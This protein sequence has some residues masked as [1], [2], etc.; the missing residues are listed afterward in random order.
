MEKR[1]KLYEGK[2]KIIYTTDY[3]NTIIQHFKDDITAFNNKKKET[4]AEKGKLNNAISTTIFKLLDANGITTHYLN[5]LPGSD[6]D[7]VCFKLDM[8]PIE[9]VIRNIVAGSLATRMGVK[10]GTALSKPIIEFYYKNDDLGDP[11]INEDHIQAFNLATEGCV[12]FLKTETTKINTILLNWFT[13]KQLTLVDMKLEFGYLALDGFK[14]KKILVGDEISP[15]TCRLWDS[16]TN[17]KLDKD[18]FRKELG[19][20]QESYQEIYNRIK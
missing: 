14:S 13:N 4:I 20:V 16:K 9:I 2:A 1:D 5:S 19:E 3:Q 6:R 12:E 18:R 17:K 7:M 10:E 8:I 15:D 11:L